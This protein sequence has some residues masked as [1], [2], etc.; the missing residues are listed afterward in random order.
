MYDKYHYPGGNGDCGVILINDGL[1]VNGDSVEVEWQGAGPTSS[2]DCR[3]DSNEFVPCK[4]CNAYSEIAG[5]Q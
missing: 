1:V 3:L 4:L 2:F 5:I